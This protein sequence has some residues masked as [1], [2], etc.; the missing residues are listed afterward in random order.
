LHT[1]VL[2]HLS[3]KTN[4]EALALEAAH[5]ALARA[6]LNGKVRVIVAQQHE[7]LEPIAV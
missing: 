3:K 6:G 5:T 1:L 7:A 2:A 4:T